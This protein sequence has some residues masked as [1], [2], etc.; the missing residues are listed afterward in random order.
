MRAPAPCCSA[1]TATRAAPSCATCS[2]SR[3]RTRSSRAPATRWPRHAEDIID[4]ADMIKLAERELMSAARSGSA[5]AG[6]LG[7]AARLDRHRDQP[8]RG[9][10][11]HLR[12]RGRAAAD[13]P[14][15]AA[16][17]RP[18]RRARHDPPAAPCH[19]ASRHHR[20][21]GRERQPGAADARPWP[22]GK[23][24]AAARRRHA[25]RP[26]HRPPRPCRHRRD[27]PAAVHG[28]AAAGADRSCEGSA[29]EARRRRSSA[30]A[31]ARERNPRSGRSPRPRR[32]WSGSAR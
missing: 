20:R 17:W 4:G 30:T 15:G 7:R 23:T 3:T 13:P 32:G 9:D 16:L 25:E 21:H 24:L 12:V 28:A 2:S 18:A 6:L 27:A 26:A 5:A 19:R 11:H 31:S 29:E 14:A 8:A 10:R 22:R 1:T